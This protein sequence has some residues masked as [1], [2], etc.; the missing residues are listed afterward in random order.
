MNPRQQRECFYVPIARLAIQ[1]I[2]AD[3]FS[4]RIVFNS[5]VQLLDAF[6]HRCLGIDI[7]LGIGSGRFI[8]GIL[9]CFGRLARLFGRGFALGNGPSHETNRSKSKHREQT[10]AHGTAPFMN[11]VIS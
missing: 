9:P 2:D 4:F 3:R 10:T 8:P 11:V 6:D 7:G 5:A 1:K